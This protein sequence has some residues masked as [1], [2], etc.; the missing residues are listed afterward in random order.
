MSTFKQV[1]EIVDLLEDPNING[2]GVKKFLVGR[3]I[4][5]IH[6]KEVAGKR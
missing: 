5:N 6:I 3:G 4:T 2:E 1:V